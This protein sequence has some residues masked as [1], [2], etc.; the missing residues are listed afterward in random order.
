M[1]VDLHGKTHKEAEEAVIRAVEDNLNKKVMLS[2]VT[3]H[4]EK[5]KQV[6]LGVLQEY[7]LQHSQLVDTRITAWV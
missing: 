1:M 3:G 6:V 2:F 5:M 7:G 4:S